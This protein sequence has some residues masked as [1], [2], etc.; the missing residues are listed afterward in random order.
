MHST[1]ITKLK[2]LVNANLFYAECYNVW[3]N[4]MFLRSTSLQTL[5]GCVSNLKSVLV[6]L[7]RSSR[8]RKRST[9]LWCAILYSIRFLPTW[10]SREACASARRTKHRW[11][12]CSVTHSYFLFVLLF[13]YY[14]QL[15]KRDNWV[16][17]S[18]VQL[19]SAV[20][21]KRQ[22]GNLVRWNWKGSDY[23]HKSEDRMFDWWLV[24]CYWGWGSIEIAQDHLPVSPR[25]LQLNSYSR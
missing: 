1:D 22:Q 19:L 17:C 14:R 8:Q 12:H 15:T 23:C 20:D 24:R 5:P 10:L 25:L 11:R 21:K 13:S 4:G 9:V 16:V 3:G 7:P 6:F 2:A 18:S